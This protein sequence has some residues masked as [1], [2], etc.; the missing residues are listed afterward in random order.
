MLNVDPQSVQD[1]FYRYKMPSIKT[2]VEGNGNGIKTVLVNL[3]EIG[4]A[5]CRSPDYVIKYISQNLGTMSITKGG[6]YIINGQFTS[7]TV[8]KEIYNFI[9][10]F[11]LCGKCRNPETEYFKEGKKLMMTC[12]ACP[13]KTT[14]MKIDK[15]YNLILKMTK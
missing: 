11:V 5:I 10:D 15:T 4:T 12:K 6:K 13:D 9:S 8:Q 7:E 3:E 1:P 14:I 2:K